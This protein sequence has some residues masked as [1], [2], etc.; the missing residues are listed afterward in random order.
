MRIEQIMNANA[1]NQYYAGVKGTS[2]V[3]SAMPSTYNQNFDL[4]VLNG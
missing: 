1:L 4:K 3:E 2:F